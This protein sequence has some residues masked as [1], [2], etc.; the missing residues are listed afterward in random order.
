VKTKYEFFLVE[1]YNQNEP[2]GW[3]AGLVGSAF[4]PLLQG[5][6]RTKEK[7]LKALM[8][9]IERRMAEGKDLFCEVHNR[10]LEEKE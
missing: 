10:W 4:C 9:K 3:C 8:Q 6:G 7:A 2:N 5:F 1:I